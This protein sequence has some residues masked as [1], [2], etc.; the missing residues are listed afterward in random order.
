MLA[1]VILFFD[2]VTLG[3]RKGV[4]PAQFLQMTLPPYPSS[5][6]PDEHG[7]IA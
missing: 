5:K 6:M 7:G 1:S 4:L 3:D 2:T